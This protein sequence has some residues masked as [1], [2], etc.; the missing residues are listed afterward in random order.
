MSSLKESAAPDR[1]RVGICRSPVICELSCG[2]LPNAIPTTFCTETSS[3][4]RDLSFLRKAGVGY[5]LMVC[6]TCI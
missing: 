2:L 5:V 1:L 3:L 4:V 6:I